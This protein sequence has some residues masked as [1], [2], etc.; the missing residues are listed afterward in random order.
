MRKILLA[1]TIAGF[2]AVAIPAQTQAQLF[3][4][5][6]SGSG[7]SSILSNG[8]FFSNLS[9]SGSNGGGGSNGGS[10]NGGGLNF[11]G[12]SSNGGGYFANIAANLFGSGRNNARFVVCSVRS[13][14]FR[15]PCDDGSVSPSGGILGF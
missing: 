10:S 7:S 4:N 9:G 14:I 3:G 11:G 12:G 8:G 5:S 1:A 2:A 15:R 13:T 6:N